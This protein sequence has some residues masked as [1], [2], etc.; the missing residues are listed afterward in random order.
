MAEQ[1][2]GVIAHLVVH[3]AA[4]A[5]E[6]YKTALGASE[7]MRVPADD[8]K[9]LLH[10]E[11]LVNGARVFVRDDFPDYREQC[12][13]GAVLTPKE[14]KTT[15]VT[16]HLEVENCDKAVERATAAG[17]TIL[18]PPMD[19]FWGARYAQVIDPF[20]HSWSFAHPLP[21]QPGQG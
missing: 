3:D 17:A 21:G 12:G 19:A 8:G 9:R 4:A 14:A 1:L 15:T 10:S 13:G 2:Q 6:F 11:I 7:V 16:L 18:M 20:G 5:L